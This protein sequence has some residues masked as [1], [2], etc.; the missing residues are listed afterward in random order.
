MSDL[1]LAPNTID[2][3]L[4]ISAGALENRD[5]A[6]FEQTIGYWRKQ[7]AGIP[8]VLELPTD[9]TRPPIKS[10]LLDRESIRL[11]QNLHESLQLLCGREGVEIFVVL[12]AAFQTLLMRYTRQEDVVVGTTPGARVKDGHF[13]GTPALNVIPIRGDLS[14]DPNFRELVARVANALR[15]ALEHREISWVQLVEAV[16]PEHDASRHPIFQA[17]FSLTDS[18]SKTALQPGSTSEP[19]ALNIDLQLHFTTGGDSLDA[20]F[21]YSADLFD[22]ATIRRMAAHFQRLLEAIVTNPHEQISRLPLLTDGERQHLLVEWNNTRTDYPREACIHHLFEAQAARTPNAVAVIFENTQFTYC[23]LN[24]RANQL[25]RYLVNLGVGPNVLVGICVERSLDMVVG[26]LG[27]LKAGGAYV[28]VDPA[29]PADRIAFMLEDA[30]V[31]VLLTQESLVSNLPRHTAALL[32]LDF[33]W[34]NIAIE[35]SENLPIRSR[36]ADCAYTIY[37]SGSTGKPKG[38]QIP[39]CA[40][41]NFLTSMAKTPGMTAHDR[42]LAVTTLSFDIAGLEIYLPL[43]LGASVEIVN[44]SVYSDGKQ[45]LERLNNSSA[46]IM[47]ATPATW[48]MLLEAGWKSSPGLKILVGGE[49]V[50]AKLANELMQR[51]ESVWNM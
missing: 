10:F 31:P 40:V 19:E 20:E 46:T 47:Q 14:G 4:N 29:F 48:R 6:D 51:A 36:A 37:T 50:P 16:E 24:A 32:R 42:L 44:R 30:E 9:R 21:V 25:A 28:P 34:S 12:L 33:D 39:H 41:V 23:E 45:L 38:V 11:P 35:S 17:A 2:E 3:A 8:A 5:K 49:A 15:E 22:A 27:I 1:D 7:L 43:T 18:L 13:S 26:L